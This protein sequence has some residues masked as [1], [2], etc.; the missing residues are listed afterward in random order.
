MPVVGRHAYVISDTGEVA[1]VSPF[2][3]DYSSMK[4]RVVDI[5]NQYDC[6]RTGISYILVI[7]NAL[8]VPSM[9]HNLLRPF[10]LHQ[11]GI[12]VHE[13]PKIHVNEPTTKD[14]SISFH[15]TGLRIPM[16]LWGIFS[17]FPT[18]KPTATMMKESDEVYLLTP[19]QFNPHDDAFAANEE[20]MLDWEGNMVEKRHRTQILLSEIEEDE[21]KVSSTTI[22]SI[23]SRTIDHVLEDTNV[24]EEQVTR[25]YQPIPHAADEISSVMAG[26]SPIL[27][28]L[29]MYERLSAR[30][31]MGKFKASIGST[32]APCKE[33]LVEDDDT[34]AT[35]PSTY[36]DSNTD[37][38]D[39]DER[40]LL[41]QIYDGSLRG[42][43]DLD[44]FMVSA[45]H[46][47]RTQGIDAAHLSKAWRISLDAAERTLDITTQRTSVR[48]NDPKLS[49]NYGTNDRM[50]RYKRIHE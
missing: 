38:D 4:I 16:S 19:S 48:T 49:R 10:I 11:A 30:S 15:E 41:G 28:E 46:A 21:T 43:I 7:R 14:H 26:I 27:D 29:S 20:N 23:E 50:L 18:S 44:E 40:Q 8:D 47:K 35:D 24:L 12:V 32:D 42:D 22:S 9:K 34:A 13:V 6:D 25:C 3:P 5:A 37:L 45:A 36:D 31:E 2:T 1:D 33:Y 17:Y 39:D